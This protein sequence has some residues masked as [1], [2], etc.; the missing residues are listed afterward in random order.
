MKMQP[1]IYTYIKPC[2]F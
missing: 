1:N 2:Q